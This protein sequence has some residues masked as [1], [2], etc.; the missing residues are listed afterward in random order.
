MSGQPVID[1]INNSDITRYNSIVYSLVNNPYLLKVI[2]QQ[3]D[4]KTLANCIAVS[5]EFHDI[6]QEVMEKRHGLQHLM[7]KHNRD[8]YDDMRPFATALTDWINSSID[9]KP[10]TA[11]ILFGG[12]KRT[13]DYRKSINTL[14]KLTSGFPNGCQIVYLDV[15]PRVIKSGQSHN[16]ITINTIA[17]NNKLAINPLIQSKMSCILLSNI[18]GIQV[19]TYRSL[20]AIVDTANI[21]CVIYLK[22]M[23]IINRSHQSFNIIRKINTEIRVLK[24]R[25]GGQVAIAGGLID[26]A[27][28]WLK[29]EPPRSLPNPNKPN[30]KARGLDETFL[31]DP[32][33]ITFGGP[34]LLAASLV[35]SY[36]WYYINQLIGGFKAELD[37]QFTLDDPNIITQGILFG[38]KMIC[39]GFYNT[40]LINAFKQHFPSVELFGFR[41]KKFMFGT[42]CPSIHEPNITVYN[43]NPNLPYHSLYPKYNSVLLLI[44]Y[45]IDP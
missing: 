43:N 42:T 22:S 17:Q 36:G 20:D 34:N 5:R 37:P 1:M 6:A 21:K 4:V 7:L 14:T 32:V 30:N 25:F 13:P 31:A 44:S 24:Q 23:K 26:A 41:S 18:S 33:I 45:R 15:G 2:C 27:K 10:R 11:F 28:C 9:F 38:N 35:L 39:K 3:M 16:T 40:V 19:N 8:I 29:G 12:Y